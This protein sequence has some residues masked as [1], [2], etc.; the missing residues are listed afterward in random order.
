MTPVFIEPRPKGRPEGTPIDDYAVESS[1]SETLKVC[2]TQQ[3]AVDWAK[4]EGY[5]VHVARVRKT[6]KGKPDH[7]RKV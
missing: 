5:A 4:T 2:N 6:D 1:A 7:W 3:D